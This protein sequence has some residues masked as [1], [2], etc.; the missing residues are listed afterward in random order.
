VLSVKSL[1]TEYPSER[2]QAIR[3]AQDVSFEVPDG[4]LFTLL[5]PSGCGKTTT[6]RSI[7]GLERQKVAEG[8]AQWGCSRLGCNLR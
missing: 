4:K 5:G 2:G 7:A 6:L 8:S 1:Y 3:A